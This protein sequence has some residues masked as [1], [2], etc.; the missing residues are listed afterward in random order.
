MF[1]EL[2]RIKIVEKYRV[3]KQMVVI[4]TVS[5]LPKVHRFRAGTVTDSRRARRPWAS[6]RPKTI[7]QVMK[8]AIVDGHTL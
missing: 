1:L 8:T 5:D 2:Y 4:E 3:C 6:V 7:F